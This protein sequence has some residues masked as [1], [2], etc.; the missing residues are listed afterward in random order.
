MLFYTQIRES[1]VNT[2]IDLSGVVVS[3]PAWITQDPGFD[4]QLSEGFQRNLLTNSK[5]ALSK[6]LGLSQLRTWSGQFLNNNY[7]GY[8][9]LP[10]II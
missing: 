3:I 9:Y 7:N 8:L 4:P 6:Q 10:F 2:S 5:M 1:Q